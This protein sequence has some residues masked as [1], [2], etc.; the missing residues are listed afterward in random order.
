MHSATQTWG[1]W[2]GPYEQQTVTAPRSRGWTSEVRLLH[3]QVSALLDRSFSSADF[4]WFPHLLDGVTDQWGLFGEGTDP[5]YEPSQPVTSQR[6]HLLIP[7]TLGVGLQHTT[8]RRTDSQTITTRLCTCTVLMDVA[9][10]SYKK[11]LP[12]YSPRKWC[13]YE[14]TFLSK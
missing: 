3:G 11:V 2:R 1:G 4:L 6:P 10:L 9:I 13:L 7:S 8:L 12:I 5:I 14:S